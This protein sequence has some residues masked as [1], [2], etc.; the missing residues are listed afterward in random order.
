MWRTM[1][2]PLFMILLT[3]LLFSLYQIQG[4]E[5]LLF[6]LV[7]C[8]ILTCYGVLAQFIGPRRVHITREFQPGR[9]TAGERAEVRISVT[10]NSWVPLLWLKIEEEAVPFKHT[11]IIFPRKRSYDCSYSYHLKAVHRGVYSYEYCKITWGDAFG[12]FTCSRR[13]HVPGE[14]IVHPSFHR[15]HPGLEEGYGESLHQQQTRNSVVEEWKGYEVREYTP[16]DGFR[17]I[18]WKSSARKG[19]LQVRIPEKSEA[20]KIYLLLDNGLDS[21]MHRGKDQVNEL[22]WKAYDSAISL[23]AS[24]LRSAYNKGVTPFI[25]TYFVQSGRAVFQGDNYTSE[26]AFSTD[27]M[28]HQLDFLARLE[29]GEGL[30]NTLDVSLPAGSEVYMVTGSLNE[31]NSK[32]ARELNAQGVRVR[33]YEM[34][35]WKQENK[36]HQTKGNSLAAEL[37]K[38]QIRVKTIASFSEIV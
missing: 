31:Q 12:W 36:T 23:C 18:H 30:R 20:N 34:T 29:P 33:F 19:K 4:G 9:V 5:T 32:L 22:S 8:M 13:V 14:L 16:R 26:A 6:L 25:A 2:S 38:E 1:I 28:L 35:D 7:S 37:E 17:S 27:K 10:I 15:S 24:M 21:Y 3:G 11:H